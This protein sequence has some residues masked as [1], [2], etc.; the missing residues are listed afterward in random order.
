MI[1]EDF[2]GKPHEIESCLGC[3]IACGKLI[4]DGCD[5]FKTKFFAVMQD[6]E[7]PI[8]GFM[9]ISP[10]RHVETFSQLTE[11]EVLDLGRLVYKVIGALKQLGTADYFDFVFE[12]KPGRH[13]HFWI[14]PKHKWM[15]EKFGKV[16]KNIGAIQEYAIRNLKTKENIEQIKSTCQKLKILLKKTPQK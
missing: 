15:S 8:D 11:E 7:L 1:L 4:Y 16:L 10:N 14:V 5:I 6:F 9:I 3:E 13:L 12:E 2:T